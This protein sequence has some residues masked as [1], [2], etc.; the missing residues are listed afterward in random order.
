M[1]QYLNEN[2]SSLNL[3]DDIIF[4]AEML[5]GQDGKICNIKYDKQPT[6]DAQNQIEKVLN[7]M[8]VFKNYCFAIKRTIILNK[9]I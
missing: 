5:V 3:L 6:L 2:I 8:P 9:H 1:P 7:E 4:N